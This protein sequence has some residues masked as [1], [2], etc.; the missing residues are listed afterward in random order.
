MTK[1][2]PGPWTT[3]PRGEDGA[4]VYA[5]AS[6]AWCGIASTHGASGSQVIRAAEAQANARLIAAAP[7]LL[8]G[9]EAMI[10]LCH[11]C[12]GRG[13]CFGPVPVGS[14]GESVYQPC[15]ECSDA[16]AAIAKAKGET[17]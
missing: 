14:V 10:G 11:G 5:L 3:N 15:P 8:R 1:H 16:R 17:P 7:D 9:L 6:V 13:R 12:R 4:E 2:T